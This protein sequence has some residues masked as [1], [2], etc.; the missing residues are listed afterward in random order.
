MTQKYPDGV[1]YSPGTVIITSAAEVEDVRG[2]VGTG[3]E[4]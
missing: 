4:K 3:A 1:V 2:I